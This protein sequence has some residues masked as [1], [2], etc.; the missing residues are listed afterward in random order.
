MN[1]IIFMRRDVRIKKPGSR[2]GHIIRYTKGGNP[3][4]GTS[5]GP[6][7]KKILIRK[8]KR[9]ALESQGKQKNIK[10]P[11]WVNLEKSFGATREQ[12]EKRFGKDLNKAKGALN[13]FVSGS[14]IHVR[15]YDSA[16]RGILSAGKFKN[17]YE[18]GKSEGMYNPESRLEA[19]SQL[20]GVSTKPPPPNNV[21]P[22][23]GYLHPKGK[24]GDEGESVNHYGNIRVTLKD[25]V[26][27]RA[28]FTVGDSFG[29]G[30]RPSPIHD[31]G[32]ESYSIYGT[33]RNVVMGKTVK[34]SSVQYVESQV[35]GGLTVE[36]IE[37]VT[38]KESDAG[39]MKTLKNLNIPFNVEI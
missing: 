35:H 33:S 24:I 27:E 32:M 13:K 21:R 11:N 17:Q 19:E 4:Y 28:T 38:L 34:E 39:I 36:D 2:G 16:L 8:Q 26:K 37:S 9:V 30:A 20:L 18:I 23:Y 12:A 22:L 25:S 29:S 6:V 7:A 10:L 3:V 5:V 14:K 15:V 31:P 1:T